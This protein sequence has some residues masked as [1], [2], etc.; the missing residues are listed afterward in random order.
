MK[1]I[2]TNP[3]LAWCS[4]VSTKKGLTTHCPFASVEACPI[5]YLSTGLLGEAGITTSLSTDDDARLRDKWK[6]HPAW[7]KTAEQNPT[8]FDKDFYSHFCPEV[9]LNVFG[10]SATLLAGYTDEIDRDSSHR[11]LTRDNVP[12]EYWRWRWS[13]LSELHYSDCPVYAVL[14]AHPT[15]PEE[16]HRPIG[17]SR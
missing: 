8:I 10:L 16:P 1:N 3:D 7:P 2:K 13:T 6:R 9:M 17:F 5:N 14:C 15:L 4:E 12:I 11:T